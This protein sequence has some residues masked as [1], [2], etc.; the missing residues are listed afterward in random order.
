MDAMS[1]SDGI[2]PSFMELTDSRNNVE[3]MEMKAKFLVYLIAR[4]YRRHD[5]GWSCS[6]MH[7]V[8]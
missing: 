5:M 2:L 4:R 8:F 3:M 1:M 6:S 7:A